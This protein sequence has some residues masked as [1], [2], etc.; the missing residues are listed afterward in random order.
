MLK[1]APT[2]YVPTFYISQVVPDDPKVPESE[3]ERGRR[4]RDR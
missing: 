1:K 4:L 2:Y 3:R